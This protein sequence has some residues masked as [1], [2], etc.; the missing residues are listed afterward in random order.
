MALSE[1]D[2][3]SPLID[4][5][6]AHEIHCVAE[7]CGED[8]FDFTPDAIT[9]SEWTRKA[10]VQINLHLARKQLDEFRERAR[11]CS[12]Q[13]SNSRINRYWESN[14]AVDQWCDMIRKLIDS[15]E[16][17]LKSNAQV[18]LPDSTDLR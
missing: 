1:V 17:H 11:N 4:F 6:T 2:I 5:I 7:C 14:S 13:P 18:Q 9:E 10:I 15:A 3:L 12:G 8:A 16:A